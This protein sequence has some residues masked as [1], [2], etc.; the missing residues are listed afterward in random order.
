MAIFGRTEIELTSRSRRKVM[1]MRQQYNKQRNFAKE[2]F[3]HSIISA[4]APIYFGPSE[5]KQNRARVKSVE[6]DVVKNARLCLH[7]HR[8][9]KRRSIIRSFHML[10]FLSSICEQ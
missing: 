9:R 1:S 2:C 10:F 4:C 8:D 6:G 7:D 3:Q 5:R